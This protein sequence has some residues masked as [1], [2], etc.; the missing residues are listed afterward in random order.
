MEA[1]IDEKEQTA[2]KKKKKKKKE[3]ILLASD[4]LRGGFDGLKEDKELPKLKELDSLL[5]DQMK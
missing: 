4:G 5:V 3:Q 2:G 1:K